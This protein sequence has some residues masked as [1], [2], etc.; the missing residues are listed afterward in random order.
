[1]NTIVLACVAIRFFNKHN[2]VYKIILTF[3]YYSTFFF[4]KALS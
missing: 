1:M 4:N 2:D 3:V